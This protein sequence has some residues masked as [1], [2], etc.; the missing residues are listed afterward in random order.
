MHLKRDKRITTR[1]SVFILL[2]AGLSMTACTGGGGGGG[3]A[4]VSPTAG[5]TQPVVRITSVNENYD[6]NHAQE[7]YVHPGDVINLSSDILDGANDFKSSGDYVEDFIWSANDSD[8]DDCDLA[9]E[10]SSCRDKSNFQ[11]NDFGVSFYVP[12]NMGETIQISVTSHYSLAVDENGTPLQDRIVLRNADYKSGYEAPTTV[13]T[14]PD[15]YEY[16]TLNPDYALA[17]YGQWVW[18]DG[19]RYFVPSTFVDDDGEPWRPY[20]H[21]YW[22]WD[23]DRGWTWLSYDPWGWMTD[24]YGVWRYHENHGWIWLP[25]EDCHYEPHTVTWFN[26]GDHVGWYPYHQAY[27]Q[28]YKQGREHGFRD[29]FEEGFRAG[30]HAND[31][32]YH[33]GFSVVRQGDVT[34]ANIYE[35][36]RVSV[37]DRSLSISVMINSVN[38]N[39][40][41]NFPGGNRDHA[42]EFIENH[43]DHA[44][45]TE[46]YEAGEAGF[47]QPKGVRSVPEVYKRLAPQN[48]DLHKPSR[49]GTVREVSSQNPTRPIQEIAPTTNGKSIV[50]APRVNDPSGK[51][52]ALPPR[53]TSPAQP[54]GRNPVTG[55][56]PV[57]SAPRGPEP[58]PNLPVYNPGKPT[59][60]PVTAKPAPEKPAPVKEPKPLPP[61]PTPKPRPVPQPAPR[62][63]PAPAPRPEPSPAPR[64]GPAP[65]PEPTPAPRPAP[66]PAPRPEPAP[67]P[68]PQPAPRPEPAPAPRPAPAPAPRPEPAPA[69]RPMPAP[70]PRPEPA[71]A[72]RPQP[73]PRPEPAP[74]PRP[75]PA[76]APRPEP[77]PRPAPAPAPRPEPAPRPAPA[78]APA[79][80]PTKPKK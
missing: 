17:G 19:V 65:R 68:R 10:E 62:P 35:V 22:S 54:E 4:P 20:R 61:E 27:A 55:S 71:P 75:A 15:D 79:P 23:T 53:S 26:D 51:S 36:T 78:P 74:A 73:A 40:C 14:N 63:A 38:H 67:A 6:P 37:I 2:S 66:A 24:H 42:R 41:N 76:P 28:G 48:S 69:P 39:T 25:F 56:H 9:T 46:T 5:I 12:Y 47:L 16:K 57:H 18:V 11:A 21:G 30:I 32:Q 77:A 13:V 70:A 45:V 64:P 59:P 52:H 49:L 60:P 80:G 29:G 7:I 58:T 43:A 8:S 50:T 33:I 1:L 31:S 34:H 3:G 72:P 44:P